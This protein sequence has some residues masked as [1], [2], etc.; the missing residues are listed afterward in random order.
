MPSRRLSGGK[1]S[2]YTF[3]TSAL[4][5]GEWSASCTG[6]AFT[7]GEWTPIT[8]RIGGWVSPSAGLYT[9]VR[10]KVICL[11]RGLNLDRPIVQSVVRHY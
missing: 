2:S 3:T 4:D 5:G 6:S 7:P 10:E 9:E 8:H 11:C 1:Y